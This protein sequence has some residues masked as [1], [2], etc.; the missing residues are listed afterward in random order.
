[1][2]LSRP[3][4]GRWADRGGSRA[5]VTIGLLSLCAGTL[6]VAFSRE[7]MGFLI[8]GAF[9]GAGSGFSIPT[10]QALAVRHVPFER[11]GAATGTYFAAFDMSFGV[12]AILWDVVAQLTSYRTMYITTLVP[13]VLGALIY[14]RFEKRMIAGKGTI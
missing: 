9:I 3:L 7:M 1:M 4:S 12:G 6:I 11:R 5:V 14:Y 2:V 10:L 13:L 8:A